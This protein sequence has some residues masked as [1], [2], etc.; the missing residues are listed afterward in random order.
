MIQICS[1][2][3]GSSGNCVYVGSNKGH[4][5]IDAGI[6]GKRIENGLKAIEIDPKSIQGLLVTHEHSDH[7]G[8]LGVM[9]RRYKMP[10]YVTKSTWRVLQKIKNVGI[11]PED[12]I[13]F[14]SPDESFL[15]EDI[16]VIP[17]KTSHDAADSVGYTFKNEN[18][19]IGLATDLGSYSEYI[20]DHLCDVNALYIEANHDVGMLQTGG[21]P[22]YLKQRILSDLGHLSNKMSGQL[23]E[24]V[25]HDNLYHI[26][27]AHLSHENNHPDVAYITIKNII[28]RSR[29]D[30]KLS[31]AERDCHSTPVVIE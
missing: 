28:D 15:I 11:I 5:L 31:V 24:Q 3:S 4:I 2:A 20:V 22:Y 26:I 30:I 16:E 19:K 29:H 9:A 10:I 25:I 1:M 7:I 27:L 14:I 6:S 21:Y 17:F 23:V 13:R 8:G 18:G 12:L